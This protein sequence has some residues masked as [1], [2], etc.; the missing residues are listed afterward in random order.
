MDPVH[1]PADEQPGRAGD[2]SVPAA[3][4]LPERAGRADLRDR[5]ATQSDFRLVGGIRFGEGWFDGR[6]WGGGPVW[7]DGHGWFDGNNWFDG[8][9]W[10]NGYGGWWFD[11]DNWFDGHNWL[12]DLN[13]PSLHN[14]LCNDG[15]PSH[16]YHGD[17][18]GWGWGGWGWQSSFGCEDLPAR[19]PVI[20]PN[21]QG[22]GAPPDVTFVPGDITAEA[23]SAAGATVTY[24]PVRAHGEVGTP[25]ITYSQSSGT[26]F[27]IGTTTVTST[28]STRAATTR[29][30]QFDITVRDTTAPA[31]TFVT[32]NITVEA[33]A[34]GTPVFFAPATAT[35]AVG[36]VTITYV[37]QSGASVVP[38]SLFPIGTTTVT[39]TA[40]DAYG[41]HSSKTFKVIV[42]DTT[43]P[44]VS[45]MNITVEATQSTGYK[46][47][48]GSFTPAV[49]WSDASGSVTL[50]YTK[51]VGTVLPFGTTSVTVTAT[52]GSGN[53]SSAT[54][55]VTVQDHTPPTITAPDVTVEATSSGRREGDVLAD[56]RRMRP[57]RRPSRCRSPPARRSRSGRRR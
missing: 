22:A 1:R 56:A 46:I 43:A 21:E 27:P 2:R 39:E 30:C 49:T 10:F 52:D 32:P 12:N 3:A 6:G 23:T 44:V 15:N 41:N 57:A 13:E 18:N 34:A 47:A 38:G 55:T 35:D 25:T 8:D 24:N 54:F 53:H 19:Q 20:L 51:S 4:G 28:S 14:L 5:R 37:T 7:V 31:F 42:Q 50:T 16:W 45:A 40:T 11:G 9:G 26:I 17:W 29:T 33:T 36:P 48:S